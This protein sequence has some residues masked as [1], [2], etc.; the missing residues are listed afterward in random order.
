ME[1]I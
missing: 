1:E